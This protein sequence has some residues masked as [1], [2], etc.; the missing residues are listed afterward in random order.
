MEI[1]EV[2]M[3]GGGAWTGLVWLKI[4]TGVGRL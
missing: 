1:E 2:G 3:G 4:G